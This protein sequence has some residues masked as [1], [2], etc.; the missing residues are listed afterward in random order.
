MLIHV[1]VFSRLFPVNETA[2]DSGTKGETHPEYIAFFLVPV[3]FLL[4]LLGMFICHILKKKGY[5]CTTDAEEPDEP[6]GE[7]EKRLEEGGREEV[8]GFCQVWTLSR[9]HGHAVRLNNH[10]A[11]R[12]LDPSSAERQ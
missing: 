8:F 9:L 1:L 5:R 2:H 7:E 10:L 4:G 6:E 3:F 12:G 11:E